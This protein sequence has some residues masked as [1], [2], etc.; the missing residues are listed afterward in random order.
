MSMSTGQGGE[1][2]APGEVGGFCESCG[3]SLEPDSNFCDACGARVATDGAVEAAADE[4]HLAPPA[5]DD[6]FQS[7][8]A[9]DDG[10]QAPP[11]ADDGPQASPAAD[12]GYQAPPAADDGPLAPPV[13]GSILGGLPPI[14]VPPQP[15]GSGLDQAP[16]APPQGPPLAAGPNLYAPL[17]YGPVYPAPSGAITAL[18][19]GIL[20]IVA[21][22]LIC[23]I[24]AIV[25][26]K[27]AQQEARELPGQPGLGQARAGYICGI[28][29][30]VWG[31]ILLI[32]IVIY[33]IILATLVHSG[34]TYYYN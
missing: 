14:D 3:H 5:A 27:R 16:W 4:G 18:I 26:G 1:P 6:R 34:E 32:L 21:L 7:L 11:A 15:V 31:A 9:A 29:G 20:G 28:I 19:L 23:S 33:V 22:P 13:A 25:I 8:L 12:D 10:L 30:T 17:G 2:L 24:P